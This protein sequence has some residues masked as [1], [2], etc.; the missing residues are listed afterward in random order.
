MSLTVG[1]GITGTVE[2]A[3]GGPIRDIFVAADDVDDPSNYYETFST[4]DGTYLLDAPEG[5]YVVSFT[6]CVGQYGDQWYNLVSNP[7]NAT[8]VAV[9]DGEVT[10]DIDATL[11]E[12]LNFGSIA[13]AVTN[14]EGDA[15]PGICVTAFDEDG[16]SFGLA[17][18][19]QNGTFEVR[20]LGNPG[21][22]PLDP[23]LMYYVDFSDC[24]GFYGEEMYDNALIPDDA[25]LVPV[26]PGENVTGINAVLQHDA[27]VNTA[28]PSITGNTGDI[29][30]TLTATNGTWDHQPSLFSYQ[31]QRCDSAGTS[32]VSITDADEQTYVTTGADATVRLRVVVAAENSVGS[33]SA[34]SAASA[35]VG[36]PSVLTA[37]VITGSPTAGASLSVSTGTWSGSP[38]SYAY[39]WQRCNT[40]VTVCTPI[41]G[42]TGSAYTVTVD[43]SEFRLN[44]KITATNAVGSTPTWTTA[45]AVAGAPGLTTAPVVSGPTN[46]SGTL[47]VTTG[48]WT[49]S[50]TS[51]AYRWQRCNTSVTSCS[52]IG[53]ATSDQYVVTSDDI[54]FRLNVKVTA[55]NAAGSTPTWTTATAIAGAPSLV[56]A[57]TISGS[58]TIGTSLSVSTG[59]WT[60]SPT[61]YAYRWQR[62]NTSVTVCTAIGGATGSDYTVTPDDSGF[63]L[64]VKVTATNAAGS[65]P[66]WTTAT[67]VA[68][69]PALVTA[70]IMSGSTTIGSTLTTSLAAWTGSPTVH[71]YQWQRCNEAV[72]ICTAIDGATA[73]STSSRPTTPAI[74]RIE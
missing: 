10:E 67:A 7:A 32:C 11:T 70:P 27:P 28:L 14:E 25:E 56:T 21:A 66:T 16:L 54:G 48:T 40:S 26:D 24:S 47:S 20:G 61:S 23:P 57:P 58:P 36:A 2:D 62:C 41:A 45:T 53:G 13:G 33:T 42:A 46:V 3:G 44:V 64:N 52:P 74:G 18:T 5:D 72:T 59:T 9:V 69:G 39:R 50:P 65:T 73:S 17:Y 15:I 38:T 22:A 34:T 68:G 60:G 37:P 4:A 8:D 19:D 29:G 63:R 35:L 1:S 49:G 55:T 51:Y 6:D 31:W 30:A 71:E 43:D 12:V